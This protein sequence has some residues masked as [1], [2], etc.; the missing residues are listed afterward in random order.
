MWLCLNDC[1]LS[2][3]SDQH[4][5]ARLMVRARRREALLNLFG[6]KVEIAETAQSDY[7]WRAFVERKVFATLVASRIEK[8]GYTN[9]KDSVRDNDLHDLYMDFWDL[10]RQYQDQ[11]SPH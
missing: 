5:P 6:N 2:V 8:I 3:V 7:R 10:Q 1:F 11:D 4:N 9:F